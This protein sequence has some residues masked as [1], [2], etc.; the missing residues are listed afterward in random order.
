M[1]ATMRRV[2]GFALI[3]VGLVAIP[4]PIVPGVPLIVAGAAMLGCNHPLVRICRTWLNNRG[5]LK[6]KRVDET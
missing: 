1:T 2:C 5:I 3:A 6:P 4:V